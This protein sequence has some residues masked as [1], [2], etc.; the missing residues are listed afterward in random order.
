MFSRR[1]FVLRDTVSFAKGFLIA[2]VFFLVVGFAVVFILNRVASE[3]AVTW[4]KLPFST[5]LILLLPG[6]VLAIAGV[7]YTWASRR[8]FAIGI[9]CYIVIDLLGLLWK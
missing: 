5:K 2:A 1:S 3:W 4:P 6:Y 8:L 9:L 7:L